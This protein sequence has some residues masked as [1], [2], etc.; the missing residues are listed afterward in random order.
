MI[1][2]F[3]T[4]EVKSLRMRARKRVFKDL[5]DFFLIACHDIAYFQSQGKREQYNIVIL[6]FQSA[7]DIKQKRIPYILI[8]AVEKRCSFGEIFLNTKLNVYVATW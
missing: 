2:T 8:G 4:L 3:A 6:L 7:V 5:Q 1:L